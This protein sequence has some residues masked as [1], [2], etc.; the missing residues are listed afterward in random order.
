MLT[1]F[2]ASVLTIGG[3]NAAPLQAGLS[4]ESSANVKWLGDIPP[5]NSYCTRMLSFFGDRGTIVTED[6]VLASDD[7]G[8]KWKVE[9]RKGEVPQSISD[10]WLASSNRLFILSGG[11]LFENSDRGSAWKPVDVGQKGIRYLAIA[12]G[13]TGKQLVLV[14][15]RSVAIT[16]ARLA[17]L[18]KYAQDSSTSSPSMVVPAISISN[19]EGASWRTVQLPEA[20]GYL[21]GV[22]M[23]GAY[24]VAWG[25]YAVYASTDGGLSWKLMNMDV[26]DEE[27]EAYPVSAAIASE[28]LRVSLKNGR[29]LAGSIA[30]RVLSTIARSP[31]PLD[32]LT[33]INQC[34]GYGITSEKTANTGQEDVLVKTEDGGVTWNSVLHSERIVALSLGTVDLYGATSDHAFRVA[35]T[36]GQNTRTCLK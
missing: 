25:P 13:R 16:R 9:K 8:L 3:V 36:T 2:L 19:D 4:G 11:A 30:G 28:R 22:E 6:A 17:E 34:T 31:A 29:I 32:H 12:G 27:E 10:A 21:D 23:A 1:L 26:P 14:G 15:E 33:F 35:V 24:G 7:G 20:I 5:D 18:P